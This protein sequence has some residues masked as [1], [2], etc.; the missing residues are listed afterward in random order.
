[1]FTQVPLRYQAEFN[2][3]Q[4]SFETGLLALQSTSSVV[5]A[6]G[7]TT[8]MANVV[9]GK[10]VTGDYF[11]LQ[12]VYEEK[13]YASGKIKG[14]RFIKREGKPTDN[15]ILTG[16]MID[17]SLRSLFDPH[18]RN[19]V[20]VVIT[21]LSVDEVNP[22]DTL[23]VLAA[24]SCL[25]LACK[26]FQGPVSSV[27]I[28]LNPL[29]DEKSNTLKLKISPNPSYSSM[30]KSIADIVVSGDG[31]NIMMLEAGCKILSEEVVGMCLDRANEE[32]KKLTE[33]QN[34]FIV[35]ATQQG[36]AK[37]L[38]LHKI[39]PE[40]KFEHYWEPFLS[41]LEEVLYGEKT[42]EQKMLALESFKNQHFSNLENLKKLTESSEFSNPE[43]LR[44]HLVSFA[45]D[46]LHGETSSIS[47]MPNLN[48]EIS[49]MQLNL[50][51]QNHSFEEIKNELEKAL[52]LVI[53][54]LVKEKILQ[55]E[56]RLDGRGLDEVRPLLIQTDVLPRVH[57]SSLFQRGETQVLNILTLGT[58]RDAQTLDDME[59][60]EET[61]KRYIHHYNFPPYSVGEIGRYG[62][63]GRREIGHGALA[64]KALVPVLPS[65]DEFPYTLRLVSECLGSN[66]STSMAATC[67]SCLSLMAGGVPI[68]APVAGVAMGLVL[69]S[70]TGDFKVL[71]DIQG[72]EDFNGDMDF[73]VTGTEK[74]ITAIQLDNKVAGLTVNI[75]KQA[76]LKAKKGRL[77]ILE[78][79]KEVIDKPK[80]TISQYA[81]GV[82]SL[83]VPQ[84]KIG[85]LIG[86]SGKTIKSIIQKYQ[87]EI[88]IMDETGK[89]YIYSQDLQQATKALNHIKSLIKDYKLGEIVSAEVFRIENYGAFAKLDGTD[90]EGLIHISQLADRRI[91]KVTDVVQ[92]GQ[93]V[94]AK[95]VEIN[96]K[97]QI[98]LSLKGL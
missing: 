28:G 48:L 52:N 70:Q 69:N 89:T 25:K 60:F 36:F 68:K 97:G 38:E 20:Q 31:K 81:P 82:L 63:P 17:R 23:S 49:Q 94:M 55:E 95:I 6:I 47:D 32:L 42:K 90:K 43:L 66:G 74:G 85:E 13:L 45:I 11:P 7:E 98:S 72:Q 21:V 87:V 78:K 93:T 50:Y 22:P 9:V 54:Q 10:P 96:D 58:L 77:F 29:L 83:I 12:V 5:A 33:I 86:P 39:T 18:I 27:R 8:V 14:S 34:E 64:E 37:S 65:E 30:D 84:A 75:L 56:K 92:I 80:E 15:A 4:L 76:L 59:D 91:E 3:Q 67:S 57:G 61:T 79:M 62:Y 44:T 16:R 46:P 73:K 71:T 1:M 35:Q 41:Q 88:D 19:E 26:D 40:K 53:K 51:E 24:S 2:G